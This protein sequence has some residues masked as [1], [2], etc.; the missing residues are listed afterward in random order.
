MG[1]ENRQPAQRRT[2]RHYRESGGDLRTHR[3]QIGSE[4]VQVV[5]ALRVPI[6]VSVSARVVG[7]D[8]ETTRV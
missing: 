5:A 6:A 8:A 1:A 4:A 3:E 2:Y 7:S